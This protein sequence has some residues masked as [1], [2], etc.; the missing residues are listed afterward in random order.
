MQQH[1]FTKTASP[2]NHSSRVNNMDIYS[3]T[4][5][6]FGGI[7]NPLEMPKRKIAKSKSRIKKLKNDHLSNLQQHV[8]GYPIPT[9]NYGVNDSR[10]D[11]RPVVSTQT[12][13]FSDSKQLRANLKHPYLNNNQIP[14]NLPHHKRL[15]FDPQKRDNKVLS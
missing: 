3:R 12:F 14:Q 6:R 8:P 1:E 13:R 2:E 11:L 15:I 4:Q 5:P 10:G 7:S 9:H